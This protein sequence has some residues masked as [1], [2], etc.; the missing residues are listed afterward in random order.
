MPGFLSSNLYYKYLS[1]LIN[2]VRADEF[3]NVSGASQGVQAD[4]DRSGSNASDGPQMQVTLPSLTPQPFLLPPADIFTCLL[5]FK[6]VLNA[7]GVQSLPLQRWYVEK[8]FSDY[9]CNTPSIL[10]SSARGQKSSHQDPEKLWRGHHSGCGQPGP[11]QP[12]PAAIRWVSTTRWMLVLVLSSKTG[13]TLNKQKVSSW[14]TW[15]CR[16]IME[17]R[18]LCKKKSFNLIREEIV[19][20]LWFGYA[21][22]APPVA[23]L[24]SFLFLSIFFHFYCS[25]WCNKSCWFLLSRC[26]LLQTFPK[27]WSNFW[28]ATNFSQSSSVSFCFRLCRKMTFGKV[29]EVGQFIREAEPEPDVKKSKGLDPES[30]GLLSL[31]TAIV[32]SSSFHLPSLCPTWACFPMLWKSRLRAREYKPDGGA[33][34]V[35][36]AAKNLLKYLNMLSSRLC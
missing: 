7:K 6:R 18:W 23:S 21:S 28:C 31:F 3:V 14:R 22:E 32:S 8:I 15:R 20:Y 2:S 19:L 17:S 12:V 10:S 4:G 35:L 11:W 9:C 1:D 30:L 16:E 13:R 25:L 36:R 34:S 24:I 33:A 29:N 27:K 5:L 26:G